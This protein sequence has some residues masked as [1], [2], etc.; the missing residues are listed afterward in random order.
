MLGEDR[1]S[2]EKT[3]MGRIL[4]N[5]DRDASIA[6]NGQIKGDVSDDAQMKHLQDSY[7]ISNKIFKTNY[8]KS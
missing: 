3:S 1:E 8:F 6:F 7:E 2:I 5:T 4:V